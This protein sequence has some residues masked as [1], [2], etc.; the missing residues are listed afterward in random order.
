MERVRPSLVDG[1]VVGLGFLGRDESEMLTSRFLRY[2]LSH[3]VSDF[4][5]GR[6]R[7][8]LVHDIG[9]ANIRELGID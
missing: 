4:G 1:R 8:Q 5:N 2:L 7:L 3:Q 6:F 9:Q